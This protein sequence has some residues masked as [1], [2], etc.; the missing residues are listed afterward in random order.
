MAMDFFKKEELDFYFKLIAANTKYRKNDP[1]SEK[2]GEKVKK[3]IFQKSNYWA[4]LV[5]KQL[6]DF[7]YEE[8]NSWNLSGSFKKYSWARLYLKNHKDKKLYVTVGVDSHQNVLIYKFDCQRAGKKKL[9]AASVKRLDDFIKANNSKSQKIKLDQLES[10]TWDTLTSATV[11]YVNK[12]LPAFKKL[13]NISTDPGKRTLTTSH[14]NI[15]LNQIL[16]GPPGTGKTY[17]TISRAIAIANPEFNL[18]QERNLVK[19]EFSRLVREGQVVFTTFHQSM[20]YEDFVEGIKPLEPKN[21]GDPLVYKVEEG[22]FQK[23]CINAAFSIAQQNKS[24]ETER[25]LDFSVAYDQYLDLA[26]E[27]ISNGN[28]VELKTKS[29]G[30]VFIEGIS[31]QGNFIV[32]HPEGKTT[33]TVSK[34]RL[35]KIAKEIPYLKEVSNINTEFR[36]IIGGSNAS[37]YW[38]V[39]NAIRTSSPFHKIVKE[40]HLSFSIEDK[41]EA[42]KTVLDEDYKKDSH[43]NFILIIDEI[44]RGNISQIFGELIT[45]L[46]ED[47]RAGAP[48]ALEVT[49]PYSKEK[50]S[51]PPNLYII[52][53]MNTADRS[54]EALDSA[55]R[56][57]FSFEEM[58]PKPELL[59]PERMIWKLWWDYPTVY[60]GKEPY[61]SKEDALFSLLEPEELLNKE[62][63]SLWKSE[64][65]NNEKNEEQIALLK[66]YHYGFNLCELLSTINNRI[67]ILLDKD[68]QIGH[69]YFMSV[70]SVK[71]LKA[72]FQHK[73]IPLLQEYFFGDFGKIGLVLGQGFVVKQESKSASVFASFDH[74]AADDF[75]E[76]PVYS[77][78]NAL[79]MTDDVFKQALADLM[80]KT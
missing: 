41:K 45:L 60:W 38:A 22:I 16:F 68:H 74:E 54:V 6:P 53:T 20:S 18:E 51:V 35:S 33:Y 50:F 1:D 66:P 72:V 59:S 70:G 55:L 44:N 21:E 79:K 62:K 48:E 12:Y 37:A 52:G 9:S 10:Y 42:I 3:A 67:E 17:H 46:E 27:E 63:V 43:K 61:Q 71:D 76:R 13:H 23:L 34:P 30:K 39:L 47:K 75:A 7:D 2:N 26:E 15:P 28:T 65:E 4:K 11:N 14:M 25:V 58:P 8:D 29:G 40:D 64:F 32:K 77:L 57:R 19:K 5:A 69:S 49:L 31:D 73:V 78:K 36:E 80:G 24:E 56:R